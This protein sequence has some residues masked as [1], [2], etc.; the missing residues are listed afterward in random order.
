MNSKQYPIEKFIPDL[1]SCPL[2]NLK[3]LENLDRENLHNIKD[4]L[5]TT[6]QN[7]PD[8]TDKNDG[9]G[10]ISLM[11]DYEGT[12]ELL[13]LSKEDLIKFVNLYYAAAVDIYKYYEYY[14][15]RFEGGFNY[16][17]GLNPFSLYLCAKYFESIGDTDKSKIAYFILLCCIIT[18]YGCYDTRT[19]NY[20]ENTFN[21]VE[22]FIEADWLTLHPQLTH[23]IGMFYLEKENYEKAKKYFE[24]GAEINYND[25]QSI[26][27]FIEVGKNEY[28]LGLLYFKGLGVE[29]DYEKA[30]ELF[31]KAADDAGE[32]SIPI[33]G[34]M[35]YNGL[36][37]E[38]DYD[39]AI[40]CYGT[41]NRYNLDLN[42]YYKYLNDS[43]KQILTEYIE[44]RLKEEDVSY[45]EIICFS[46]T[47][48]DKL[49]N[50][51]ESKRLEKTALEIAKNTP[52]AERTEQMDNQ[53]ARYAL[54]ELEKTLEKTT[55]NT[56]NIP[57]S[58]KPGDIFT[59]GC[60]NKEPIEWKVL[61]RDSDGAF[62]VVSTKILFKLD[63]NNLPKWLNNTFLNYSFTEEEKKHIKPHDYKD[64]MS[65]DDTYIYVPEQDQLTKIEGEYE[66]GTIKQT[67]FAKNQSINNE[68]MCFDAESIYPNGKKVRLI[69][70]STIKGI[71]PAMD[72]F[73]DEIK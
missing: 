63:Y 59:F 19:F 66:E 4:L 26:E 25:R 41:C 22:N 37:V 46:N 20:L 42:V 69:S 34:D 58:L 50:Y 60:F 64:F 49:D 62:Y 33:I 45:D 28:E 2:A 31:E 43:Q 15:N 53:Y 52:I 61:E 73:I 14:Y 68:V 36:G 72:V 11:M 71:R 47:Y 40:N 65:F 9:E 21:V 39:E 7:N 23:N 30:L 27:P 24:M 6:E 3:E 44:K 48:K 5:N 17:F 1:K 38:K 35:Y 57:K 67:E 13:S 18:S 12:A 32:P 56:G 51:E 29:Q 10:I 70:K 54:S 8:E 55:Q 16:L